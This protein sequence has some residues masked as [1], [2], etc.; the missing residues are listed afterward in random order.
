MPGRA[1]RRRTRLAHRTVDLERVAAGAA[2]VLVA[3][4][5]VSLRPLTCP[6]YSDILDDVTGPEQSVRDGLRTAAPDAAAASTPDP[7]PQQPTPQEAAPQQPGP[8]PGRAGRILRGAG[9]GIAAGGRGVHRWSRRPWGRFV[10]PALAI[11]A[12]LAATGATGRWGV[13]A[14]APPVHASPSPAPSAVDS[15]APAPGN[16]NPVLPNPS[17]TPELPGA[18]TRPVDA[19]ASWA[20]KMAPATSVPVTALQ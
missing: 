5:D 20:R 6:A 18:S 15:Q 7:A 11:A 4:H 14:A 3:R 13:P 10:L 2:T 19:L 9:R 1:R 16:E 17:T 8:R 12:V